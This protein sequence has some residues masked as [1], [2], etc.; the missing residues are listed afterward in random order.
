M[1]SHPYILPIE[2]QTLIMYFRSPAVGVFKISLALHQ[3]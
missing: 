1:G 2:G 3:L